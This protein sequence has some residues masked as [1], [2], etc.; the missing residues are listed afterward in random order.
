MI[1]KIRN[2]LTSKRLRDYFSIG[3]VGAYIIGLVALSV[4]WEGAKV[5]QRNYTLLKQVS[6][7]EQQVEIAQVKVENQK[8]QNEYYKTDA[9]LELAARQQFNKAAPGEKLLIVPKNIALSKLP[10]DTTVKETPV[11]AVST[12]LSNWQAW[13]QFLSGRAL[14]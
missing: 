9:F 4:A 5:V 13:L 11:A 10:P 3:A 8:L 7:L 14:D 12:H 1:T 6:V 2:K